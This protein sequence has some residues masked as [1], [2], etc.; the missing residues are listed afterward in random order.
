[1]S[2]QRALVSL[3]TA[4]IVSKLFSSPWTAKL[5][6]YQ[7]SQRRKNSSIDDL[8]KVVATYAPPELSEPAMTRTLG[9]LMFDAVAA[10]LESFQLAFERTAYALAKNTMSR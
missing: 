10:L 1:M 6:E 8:E 7:T 5:M 4:S 9:I 3:K 2:G